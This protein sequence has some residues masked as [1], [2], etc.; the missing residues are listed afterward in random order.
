MLGSALIVFREVLEA[1]LV[2]GIILAATKGV[3]GRTR[4][5]A[6]GMAA[7]VLGAGLVAA[8]A[9][10][11]ADMME[12]AGQDVFNAA[13]LALAAAM[14]G[15]HTVWMARHGRELAQQMNA[16]GRAVTLGERTLTA[17]AAVVALAVLR[18]GAE[19]V[20]FLYGIRVS[21]N[22]SLAALLAGIALGLMGGAAVSW[23]IYRGL[24]RIPTKRLFTVTGWLLTLLAAG[25]AA[26]AARFASSAGLLPEGTA[27]WDSSWL[28]RESSV[29]GRALHALVGYMDHPA[30][31]ELLAWI[32]TFIVLLLASQVLAPKRN[33]Q[34][35]A[36]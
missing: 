24:V 19:V 34:G 8:A 1:G 13:V 9:G 30:L 17:L 36:A 4:W 31:P 26:Q 21:A 27:L 2:I 29:P 15:A 32:A 35:T 7:G 11:I 14:L 22:E 25:M 12:G 5:I 20:L 10:Q 18:E 23:M 16:L 33:P 28:L 6:A 3:P